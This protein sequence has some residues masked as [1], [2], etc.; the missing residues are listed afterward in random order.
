[1]DTKEQ[2]CA[3]VALGAQVRSKFHANQS[4]FQEN[5]TYW[6]LLS[7]VYIYFTLHLKMFFLHCEQ[8]KPYQR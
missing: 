4:S 7:F 3:T 8:K 6:N 5:I 1:M 2:D